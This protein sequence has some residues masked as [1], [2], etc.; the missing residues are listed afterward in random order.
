MVELIVAVDG[1]SYQQAKEKGILVLLAKARERKL[2]WGVKINDMLYSGHASQ[3]LSSLHT[4]FGLGVMADVKLHDIPTTMENS[5]A[6][7]VE[8]GADIVT[9]HCSSNFR[10]K[11]EET[12]KHL[13]GVTTL[14]SF[15]DLEVKW[16]YDKSTEEIVKAFSDI[17]LMNHYEY[18]VSSVKDL[19]FIR[20]NPLKKICTGIR[21]AWYPDRHDQ[22]RISSIKEAIRMEADF[23]VLGRP[24]TCQEDILGAI[25]RVFAETQ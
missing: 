25:E 11:D 8:T 22:V 23:I 9:I 12:L 19:S 10:P 15:T 18:I 7:L 24:I 2:I 13:A 3:I 20:G 16:I 1:I 17:A 5:I 21:P 14:T 4:D 6:N